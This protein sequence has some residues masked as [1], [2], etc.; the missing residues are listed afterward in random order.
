LT[1]EK[2]KDVTDMIRRAQAKHS[3]LVRVLLF[4]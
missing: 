1:F 3:W 4:P 2:T